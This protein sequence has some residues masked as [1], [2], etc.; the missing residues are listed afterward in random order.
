MTDRRLFS[1]DF[2]DAGSGPLTVLLHSSMSGARQWG[3]LTGAL[4][5]RFRVR[6]INLYGYGKTP[7]WPSQQSPTL[8][9]YA[10]LVVSTVPREETGITL[11]GHSFGGAVA[12][13]AAR[14]LGERVTKL[15]L[16]EPSIFYLLRMGGRSEAYAEIA[17]VAY[18]ITRLSPEDAAE[19]FITFWTGAESWQSTPPERRAI[20]ARSVRLVRHEFAAAFSGHATLEQ[21][22]K[23]LPKRTLVMWAA[24]TTRPSR[25]LV[26]LLALTHDAWEF[27]RVPEGGHMS[28]LTHPQ[29]V[30]PAIAAF[31][32]R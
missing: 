25:E 30:N 21:W 6:A 23:A 26:D 12:M 28:P 18:D 15:V 1:T 5:D 9:D 29:L 16:L 17:S 24:G 10:D 22:K 13:Q 4:K 11:V 8:D 31:L 7:A 27:T 20:Y 32:A 14:R 3:S 2:V 19:R